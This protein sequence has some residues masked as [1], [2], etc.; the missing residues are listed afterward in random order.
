MK[1]KYV[2]L[3]YG[4]KKVAVRGTQDAPPTGAEETGGGFCYDAA[5]QV[6]RSL[7]VA[8]RGNIVGIIYV[9]ADACSVKSETYLIR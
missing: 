4:Q 6:T 3:A 5:T 8:F 9:D 7:L 1:T 2:S